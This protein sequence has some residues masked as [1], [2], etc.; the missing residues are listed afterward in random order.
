MFCAIRCRSGLIIIAAVVA[1]E[2]P[3]RIHDA[4]DLLSL[5]TH[6]GWPDWQAIT[7]ERGREGRH[8]LGAALALLEGREGRTIN[9]LDESEM[10]RVLDQA[11]RFSTQRYWVGSEHRWT[12]ARDEHRKEYEVARATLL[13]R[14]EISDRTP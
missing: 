12:S 1:I 2:Y 13:S 6:N 11:S 8:N 10:Q 5:D 9:L 4:F 3:E 7:A 14:P